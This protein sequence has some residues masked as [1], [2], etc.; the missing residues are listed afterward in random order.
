MRAF[1]CQ[2]R[3]AQTMNVFSSIRKKH[4]AKT[5]TWA[6]L[7]CATALVPAIASAYPDK[8]IHIIVPYPAGGV[9][10]KVARDAADELGKRFKQSVVVEN[11]SGAAGNIG[12]EWV[13]RQPA[14]GYTLLLAPASNLTVQTAL[15]KRLNYNLEKDFTPVSLLVLTPQVLVVNPK[16]PVNNVRELVE[17]SRKNPNQV[18]FGSSVGA[19]AHLAGERLKTET[20]AH[21]T[22]IPYQGSVPALNDLLGGQIQFMFTEVATAIPYIRTGKLK[23]IA[24]AYKER[25]PWVPDVPTANESGLK[26]FEVTSWYAIVARS[27]TPPEIVQRVSRELNDIVQAPAF[28]K[29]YDEIGAFTVGGTPEELG[30]FI[31]SES[32]KWT[33]I[34]K[35][36]GIEPN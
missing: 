2:Q 34:V 13:A 14:D 32:V 25:A 19:Y 35:Q 22:A 33:A 24:V 3:T 17:Y 21:F 9:A 23:P 26:D 12:F 8:P 11:R 6:A 16:L 36:A 29:R 20:D 15:F 7:A 1:S 18:N 31:K 5:L 27:G 28:K 4:I 10:D 30:R